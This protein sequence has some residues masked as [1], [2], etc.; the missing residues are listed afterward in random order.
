MWER[1]GRIKE[2]YQRV[3]KFYQINTT[4]DAN[5][6]V[7]DI[8]WAQKPIEKNEGRYLLRTTLNEQNI[9]VRQCSEPTQKVSAIYQSLNYKEKPF[10]RKKFV[11]PQPEIIWVSIKSWGEESN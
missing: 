6:K 1:I 10:S 11:V 8:I 3:G 9:V 5:G 4:Q 7:I 2:K